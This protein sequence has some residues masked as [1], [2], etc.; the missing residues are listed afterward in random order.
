MT[1]RIEADRLIPGRGSPVDDA[2]LVLDGSLITYAGTR[3]GAPRA[4][5]RDDVVRVPT[6]MP[7]LWECHGHLIGMRSFDMSTL[8]REPIALHAARIAG[9]LRA[10]L[11]AGV[12]SVREAGGLGV[13]V[14]RAVDEGTIP[15]PTVYAAGAI[16]STTGGHA[17]EHDL[18]LPWVHELAHKDGLGAVC[19]GVPEVMRATREQLRKNARV[20]KV[21]A[22][23][24]VLSIVDHPIHQQFTV[25]ELKAI[26]EVAG[27][28]DR[29]VMAHCHGKPGIVAALEA[30]VK[31]IEHGSYMDEETSAMMVEQDALLVA[32]RYIV[33]QLLEFGR[34]ASVDPRSMTK[35]E[36]FHE[37]H[38]EGMT[39][40]HE[41]GVRFAMGTDIA[42]SGPD[43][44]N[45]WGQNGRE[46]PLMAKFGLSSM[47]II[48]AS[49]ANGPDTL[50]PQAPRSGQLAEG[51]DAD[52]IA[53]AGDP[54]GDI[55]LFADPDNVTHVWKAGA[56][57][58]GPVPD[59]LSDGEAARSRLLV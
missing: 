52:V 24:G 31:T 39:I 47:E 34:V 58:K 7:G 48:E 56:L 42:L 50:G 9:D 18:P 40:A 13:Q 53:V 21:C 36:A 15:G 26:V 32:T 1:I 12:T 11:H 17:D 38:L 54:V 35:M 57:V 3:D 45:A 28:A 30:G 20:I 22:S 46:L 2:V 4:D 43:L 44:P 55:G 6:V 19:D 16:L 41:H 37:R 33:E 8:Y 29:V 27:M 49:T 5:D 59:A 10:A 25:E 23:G 14:A 51:Y